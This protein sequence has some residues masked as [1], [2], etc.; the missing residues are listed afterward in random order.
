MGNTRPS[1]PWTAILAAHSWQ[2]SPRPRPTGTCGRTWPTSAEPTLCSPT[3]PS[4]SSTAA[5]AAP[6]NPLSV[7]ALLAARTENKTIPDEQAART[8]IAI[9]IAEETAN[10]TD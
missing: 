7:T 5:P 4:A 3:T 9:A 10:A 1:R 2:T 6:I 8:A